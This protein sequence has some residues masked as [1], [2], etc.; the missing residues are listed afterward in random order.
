ML[1]G[2]RVVPKLPATTDSSLGLS[3]LQLRESMSANDPR[4]DLV[5]SLSTPWGVEIHQDGPVP[6]HHLDCGLIH[7][8]NFA[9]GIGPAEARQDHLLLLI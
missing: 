6:L 1:I 8:E 7:F 4:K 9:F 2:V 3:F 5:Y